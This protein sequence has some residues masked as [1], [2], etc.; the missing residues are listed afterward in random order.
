MTFLRP[1][2]IPE[3]RGSKVED[4]QD[5]DQLACFI[6]GESRCFPIEILFTDKVSISSLF[7]LSTNFLVAMQIHI[8]QYFITLPCRKNIYSVMYYCNKE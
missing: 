5:G 6:L 2:D 3:D 8:D 7:L 4:Y 1:I